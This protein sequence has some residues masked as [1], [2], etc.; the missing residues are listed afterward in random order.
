MRR[1]REW[2]TI[3]K[4]MLAENFPECMKDFICQIRNPEV[5]QGQ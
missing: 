4:K 5:S 3:C 1:E 2:E